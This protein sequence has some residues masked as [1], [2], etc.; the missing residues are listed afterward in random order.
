M[1]TP[2]LLIRAISGLIAVENDS[3]LLLALAVLNDSSLIAEETIID[4]SALLEVFGILKMKKRNK[5]C[6][7]ERLK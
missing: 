5:S 3:R 7:S 6:L 2:C 4:G 1:D